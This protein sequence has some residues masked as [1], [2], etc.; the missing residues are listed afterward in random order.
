MKVEGE[1]HYRGVWLH[2]F[3]E[4]KDNKEKTTLRTIED[5]DYNERITLRT[6]SRELS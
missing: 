6:L 3:V 5:K 2:H 1:A 4:D